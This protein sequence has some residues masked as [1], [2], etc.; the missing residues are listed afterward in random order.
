MPTSALAFTWTVGVISDSTEPRLS[1]WLAENQLGTDSIT[2]NMLAFLLVIIQGA[3][4]TSERQFGIVETRVHS[5]IEVASEVNVLRDPTY[6]FGIDLQ[7]D[8]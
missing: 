7:L 8:L 2:V 5:H 4:L 1:S 3:S 6:T